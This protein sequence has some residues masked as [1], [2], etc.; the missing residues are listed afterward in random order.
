MYMVPYLS[1]RALPHPHCPPFCF[2]FVSFMLIHSFV[3]LNIAAQNQSNL[4]HVPSVH[5]HPF[6]PHQKIVVLEFAMQCIPAQMV[7]RVDSDGEPTPIPIS[8]TAAIGQ[9]CANLCIQWLKSDHN[10]FR[11]KNDVSIVDPI[12]CIAI[13]YLFHRHN[14]VRVVRMY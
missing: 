10:R 2:V 3:Y 4:L 7:F 8:H 1:S 11:I 5:V 14:V 13:M 12:Q 6:S 9:G